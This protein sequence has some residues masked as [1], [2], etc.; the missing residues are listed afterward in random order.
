MASDSSSARPATRSNTDAEVERAN[1]VI[2]DPLRAY[3]D[4][5]TDDQRTLSHQQ[6]AL[7]ARRRPGRP[8][9]PSSLAGTKR[10]FFLNRRLARGVTRYQLRWRGH[11]TADDEW[12]RLEVL[13]HCPGKVAG[14][15]APVPR[16]RAGRGTGWGVAPSVLLPPAVHPRART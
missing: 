14:Y 13:A 2:S 12:L 6:G 9:R 16:R 3:A 5:R 10:S 8:S 15:D 1:G 7:D 11:T 4:G